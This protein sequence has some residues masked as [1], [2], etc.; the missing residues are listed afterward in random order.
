[1]WKM[2]REMDKYHHLYLL[3]ALPCSA[4]H[5]DIGTSPS[6][7]PRARTFTAICSSSSLPQGA[8]GHL[9]PLLVKSDELRIKFGSE[10]GGGTLNWSF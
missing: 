3:G 1:M 10:N 6:C 5:L 8:K 7:S 2:F 9:T 4:S